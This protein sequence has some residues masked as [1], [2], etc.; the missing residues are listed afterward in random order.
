MSSCLTASTRINKVLRT[1][2]RNTEVPYQPGV[3]EELPG[4]QAPHGNSEINKFNLGKTEADSLQTT[5]K[6]KYLQHVS[7][8]EH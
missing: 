5:A 7:E 1:A 2:R 6:R 4:L 8:I 3:W